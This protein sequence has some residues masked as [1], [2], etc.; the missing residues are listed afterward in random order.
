M[1]VVDTTIW[2]D[3]LQGRSSPQTEWLDHNL[4]VEGF[5]LTDL[6][7]CEVLQGFRNDASFP[8]FREDLLRFQIY[9]TGGAELAIA[10]ADHYRW[11][12]KKGITIRS[13]IDC[14]T[15]AFCMRERHSLL[16]NDRG[17]DPFE[18]HL[19]LKVIRP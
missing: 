7:L 1:I 10:A 17:F 5:A 4:T 18:K 15:A 16:H 8:L 9:K 12:R 13:T 11:L 2:I 19:G 3:V 6:I 14:V